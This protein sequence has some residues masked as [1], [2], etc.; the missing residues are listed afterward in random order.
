MSTFYNKEIDQLASGCPICES[1]QRRLD[2]TPD[3]D[4]DWFEVHLKA[5]H[6]MHR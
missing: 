5:Q 3:A 1:V 4:L 6:G 2:T